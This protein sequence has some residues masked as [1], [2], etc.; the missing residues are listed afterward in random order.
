MAENQNHSNGVAAV[1]GENTDSPSR[2][3][4]AYVNAHHAT[5][6]P[7][8]NGTSGVIISNKGNCLL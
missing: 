4:T 8:N 1:A 5:A 6:S 2:P 3:Y 7:V